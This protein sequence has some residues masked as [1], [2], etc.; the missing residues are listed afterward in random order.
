M[1]FLV[2]AACAMGAG[3]AIAWQK[4]VQPFI[5]GDLLKIVLAAA[6]VPAAWG[7]TDAFRRPG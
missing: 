5:L 7:L 2:I 4:G 1:A 3:A 6:A